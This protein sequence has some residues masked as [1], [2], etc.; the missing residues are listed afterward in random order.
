MRNPVV[1]VVSLTLSIL[2]LLPALLLAQPPDIGV[3]QLLFEPVPLVEGTPVTA[4]TLISFNAVQSEIPVAVVSESRYSEDER[5]QMRADVERY[6]TVIGDSEASEGPFSDKLREDLFA[7]G[8]LYQQL[9]DHD[10]ALKIFERTLNVSRINNGLESLDQVEVLETMAATYASL[11]KATD[12][13]AMMDSAYN[14]QLKLYGENTTEMVPAQRKLGDWNTQAFMQRS[15]ILVN[16]PRMNVQQFVSDPR[17]YI[18]PNTDIRATPLYKLYQARG[19]YLNAIRTL[20]DARDFTHP[21]LM[22][23]ER[24][25]LTNFLLST[26][27]ENILYEPDFYLTRKKSKTAS[28]LDQNTIEL[29][30]SDDY[31]LGRESHKRRMAYLVADQKRSA[32]QLVTAM[33]EEADWDVLFGRKTEGADKYNAAYKF[34]NENPVILAEAGTV[35]YPAVPVVLPTYLPAPNSRERLGIAA[36][37]PV[38]YFGYI[39]VS[40]ALTKFGKAR[41]IK[42]LGT[43]GEITRNMEI[44]LN[45]YLRRVQFRPRYQGT[46]VDTGVLTLRYYV[47]L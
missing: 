15:S 36:D 32:A 6:L 11:E 10:N 23:L 40:F 28:R 24:K 25:L 9:E 47:G 21:E 5:Q 27:R 37:A 26:H 45:E 38:N 8:L 44:R 35:I 30:N 1:S 33:L 39:D 2:G 13:D 41:K 4:R 12:A 20:V 34:F 22:E 16:I 7:T 29:M 42:Q 43:G 31:D 18:D 14:V 19:N 3:V 46:L 17:N